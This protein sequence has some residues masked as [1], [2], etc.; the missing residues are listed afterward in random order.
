M[1]LSHYFH[2]SQLDMNPVQDILLGP[3]NIASM[4]ARVR[5]ITLDFMVSHEP[6]TLS[7][8]YK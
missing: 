7:H 6:H 3:L 1:V 5:Q 8:H 2:L 4:F